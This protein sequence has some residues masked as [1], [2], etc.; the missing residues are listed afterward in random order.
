[1]AKLSFYTKEMAELCE[2]YIKKGYWQ[3]KSFVDHWEQNAQLYPDKESLVDSRMR[4]TWSK[5]KQLVDRVALSFLK[6]GLKKDESVAVLLPWCVEFC[7]I[8]AAHEKAGII[9]IQLAPTLRH[10]EL[11]HI[12]R[13]TGAKMVIIPWRYRDFDYFNMI[14]EIRPNLPYL[15]YI[16]IAGDEVPERAISLK[17]MLNHPLEEE[18]HPDYLSS[19]RH[20]PFEMSFLLHTTGTTGLP[21]LVGSTQAAHEWV[22]RVHQSET[23]DKL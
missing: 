1:M 6:L 20:S 13:V 2:S 17:E 23:G 7:L 12:L 21:K 11:E 10:E 22:G 4:L 19:N 8:R 15:K 3:K 9:L 16:L 5:V 14:E 18:F